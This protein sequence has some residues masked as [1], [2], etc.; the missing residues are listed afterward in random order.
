MKKVCKAIATVV[1]IA[2]AGSLAACAG[3]TFRLP[4]ERTAELPPDKGLILFNAD[5]VGKTPVRRIQY[6]DNEQRVDYA[7]Y[8][9]NGAQAEFIYMETPYSLWVAFEFPYTIRDKVEAWKF[10]KGQAIEWDEAVLIRT[11]L[12]QVFY[13]PYRLTG[14]DRSC[15]GMSGEW[16]IAVEDPKLRPERIMFGYYCAPP[17]KTLSEKEILTLV[18]RI[19]LKGTTVRATNY[20]ARIGNFYGDIDDNFG[21]SQQS[22]KAV[23]LAQGVKTPDPAGIDEFPFDYAVYY[24]P[25]GDGDFDD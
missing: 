6:S 7:L 3:A 19:G 13:R 8:K 10:S 16:D 4:G 15:V 17:G 2:A 23:E 1:L 18:D 5:T 11:A 14:M 25:G 20:A 21:G 12:G 9:G 22:A 24:N